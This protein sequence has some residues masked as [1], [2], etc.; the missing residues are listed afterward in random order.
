M[1]YMLNDPHTGEA[2]PSPTLAH[3]PTTQ[4]SCTVYSVQI[5]HLE[6]GSDPRALRLP[7]SPRPLDRPES[8]NNGQILCIHVYNYFWSVI[9][10]AIIFLP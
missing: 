6:D 1:S 4:M 5:I 8:E 10:F 3:R 2:L 7:S 9:N